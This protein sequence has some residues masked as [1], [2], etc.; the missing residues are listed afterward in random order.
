MYTGKFP[1]PLNIK[2]PVLGTLSIIELHVS[3]I[4]DSAS[5]S[6][7]PNLLVL[8]QEQQAFEWKTFGYRYSYFDIH[9]LQQKIPDYECLRVG[10]ESMPYYAK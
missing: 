10:Q 8:D 3:G 7:M 9:F 5:W 4:V 1:F 2:F 6:I